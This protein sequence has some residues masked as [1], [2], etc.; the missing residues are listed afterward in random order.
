M[1]LLLIESAAG[2]TEIPGDGELTI[3][4]TVSDR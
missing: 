4:Q 3:T 1:D 2:G